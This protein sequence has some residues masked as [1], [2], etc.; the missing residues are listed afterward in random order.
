MY[1]VHT[2]K[3]GY[4]YAH[5]DKHNICILNGDRNSTRAMKHCFE[6]KTNKFYLVNK[7]SAEI[8]LESSH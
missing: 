3:S 4:G 1:I 7:D 8:P 6:S 2:T 5:T